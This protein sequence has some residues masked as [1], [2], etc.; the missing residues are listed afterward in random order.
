MNES[1]AIITAL[2][3]LAEIN[4]RR[5]TAFGSVPFAA[6]F[7]GLY[8]DRGNKGVGLRTG[9]PQRRTRRPDLLFEAAANLVDQRHP[10]HA[11]RRG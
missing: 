2:T 5:S 1:L 10:V 6:G 9:E 11:G 8:S 4:N 3:R 7:C